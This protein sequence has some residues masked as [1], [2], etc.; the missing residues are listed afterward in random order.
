[1]PTSSTTPPTAAPPVQVGTTVHL[2]RRWDRHDD[3]ISVYFS[4]AAALAALA[5]VVRADWSDIAHLAEV[6]DTP[7]GLSY[8]EV[9]MAFYEVDG[10]AGGPEA[11]TTGESVDD[12]GF[13]IVEE[14]IAGPEPDEVS[15]RLATLRVLDGDPA[16]DEVPAVTYCLEAAGLTVAVFP[17]PDGYPAVLITP[18]GHLSGIPV[19][20]RLEDPF[21]P[22]GFEHTHLVS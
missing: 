8:A 18:E 17:G 4:Y 19:T 14:P 12:G 21:R 11:P 15:L 5:A 20:V 9:V 13:A 7:D 6:P 1:M 10:G 22:G 2:L 16:E 3:H